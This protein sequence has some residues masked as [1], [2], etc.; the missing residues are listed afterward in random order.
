MR[1]CFAVVCVCVVLFFLC[2]VPTTS[3]GGR[4]IWYMRFI[5]VVVFFVCVWCVSTTV[6]GGRLVLCVRSCVVG[7]VCVF[8]FNGRPGGRLTW[9]N[10][11]CLV[12]VCVR[13]FFL[14]RV[15]WS[16]MGI[17]VYVV[18]LCV[19]FVFFVF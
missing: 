18:L 9:C 5:G 10:C 12:V 14:D 15:M 2:G 8:F 3:I 7:D 11:I 13:F 19:C 1:L 17:C 16:C 4:L 6:I